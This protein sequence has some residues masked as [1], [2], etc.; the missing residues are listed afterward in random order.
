MSDFVVMSLT[1]CN[2]GTIQKLPLGFNIT[3]QLKNV[4][5]ISDNVGRDS[6]VGIVTHYGLGGP[7]I[8]SRWGGRFSAAV[9]SGPGVHPAS[10]TIGIGSFPGIKRPGRG[11]DHPPPFGAEVKE[12]V[13]LYI[14][15]PSG[16]LWPV[17][18]WNL[19]TVYIL[20]YRHT[21]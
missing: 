16:P 3:T 19:L 6:A 14:Y 9:Q 17:Q 13:E 21:L 1:E 8:E 7:R 5:T 10:Y 11:V 15:S 18:G 2:I 4:R 20:Q 12:R